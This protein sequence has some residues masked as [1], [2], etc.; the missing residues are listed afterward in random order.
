[1]MA[2]FVKMSADIIRLLEE[3]ADGWIYLLKTWIK[4]DGIINSVARIGKE[5]RN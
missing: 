4:G 5:P 2:W 1:M 3:I